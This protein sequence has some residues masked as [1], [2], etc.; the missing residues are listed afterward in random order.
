MRQAI[1]GCYAD[2]CPAGQAALKSMCGSPGDL[3]ACRDRARDKAHSLRGCLRRPCTRMSPE[4]QSIMSAIF[5]GKR[6][7]VK[8][9]DCSDAFKE[10]W[11]EAG[12]Q[13]EC[14]L[15]SKRSNLGYAPQRFESEAK[16]MASVA[17]MP[18]RF[19]TTCVQ[20]ANDRASREEGK[21]MRQHL[22]W[23]DERALMLIA[24]PWA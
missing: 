7:A 14:P 3:P 23:I 16:P 5:H 21:T 4:A 24:C 8:M 11:Q 9:I 15:Q 22:R 19:L 2:G 13:A 12:R 18:A 20:I 1:R 6:S 17:L 10:M